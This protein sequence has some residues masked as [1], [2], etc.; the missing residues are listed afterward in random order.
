MRYHVTFYTE[1]DDHALIMDHLALIGG[2]DVDIKEVPDLPLT[3]GGEPK[4]PRV[5]DVEN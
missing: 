4:I 2:Y 3:P 5:E 1:I